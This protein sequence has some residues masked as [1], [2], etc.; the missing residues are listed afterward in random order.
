M[1]QNAAIATMADA[2]VVNIETFGIA[3]ENA[4]ISN[5]G[6]AVAADTSRRPL[7]VKP[8]GTA[9]PDGAIRNRKFLHAIKA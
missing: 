6:D 3:A 8:S 1:N 4:D 2:V 7:Q 9:V 5:P